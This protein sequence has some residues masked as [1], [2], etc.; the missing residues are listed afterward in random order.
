MSICKCGA[1]LQRISSENGRIQECTGCA[2]QW[3]CIRQHEI[4]NSEQG[5]SACQKNSLKITENG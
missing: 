3:P 5:D 4:A 1:K 2:R